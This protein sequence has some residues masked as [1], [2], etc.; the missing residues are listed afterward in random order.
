[1]PT[2][3]IH[4]P[5]SLNARFAMMAAMQVRSFVRYADLPGDWRI[6]F[7]TS[8]DSTLTPDSPE[9]AWTKDYPVSFRAV[10]RDLWTRFGYD[11]TGLQ[12]MTHEHTADV[13]LS[14]DADTVVTGS[15]AELVHRVAGSDALHAR[16]AWQPP[17]ID[18]RTVFHAAGLPWKDWGLMYGGQGIDLL[19]D[20]WCPPYFNGGFLAMPRSLADDLTKTLPSDIAFVHKGFPGV[21]AFQIAL[22]LNVV[23]QAYPFVALDERYNM[24]HAEFGRQTFMDPDS[25]ARRNASI[26]AARDP[27]IVHYCAATDS[28]RKDRD[29]ASRAAI[30][31][32]CNRTDVTG[33][34][35]RLQDACRD[36]LPL[37]ERERA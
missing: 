22:C 1:M 7:T 13:L 8:L 24:G 20:D 35:S 17:T 28:F 16:V 3:E 21:F 2:T 37:M 30:E 19:A 5:L 36:A 10:T 26:T 29:L 11:G 12:S 6:V 31:A 23:R 15:L 18:L 34:A 33:V 14:M 27:R 32:F 25:V 9:F 4:V